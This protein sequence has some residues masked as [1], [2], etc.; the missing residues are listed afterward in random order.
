[1]RAWLMAVLLLAG[2]S[3]EIGGDPAGADAAVND[4][5]GGGEG[6]A[7]EPDGGAT[8]PIL[9]DGDF[10]I[11]TFDTGNIDG[12]CTMLAPNGDRSWGVE[13]ATFSV[14]EDRT[15][16]TAR[17]LSNGESGYLYGLEN[18]GRWGFVRY[19]QGDVWGGGNCGPIVWNT[20]EPVATAGRDIRIDLQVYPDTEKLFTENDSWIMFAVNLWFSSPDL[21]L[22]GGDLNGRKPLVMDLILDHACTMPGCAYGHKESE[23]AYHYQAS[24]VSEAPTPGTW[25]PVS[26]DVSEHLAQAVEHFELPAAAAE[27][28]KLY[29]VEFVIELY[30]AEGAASIDDF[31]LSVE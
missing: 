21:P 19:I 31:V 4:A 8:G 30:R 17:F 10:A 1:M 6:D 28:L 20:F 27:S 3:S 16:D 15:I 12:S 9:R 7:S 13:A 22:E 18:R 26:M 11:P 24:V 2:C 5:A 25:N 29:Q 23:S 14:P